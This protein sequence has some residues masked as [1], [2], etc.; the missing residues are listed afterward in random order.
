M[1]CV[2]SIK[3]EY[4]G[5]T[6]SGESVETHDMAQLDHGAAVDTDARHHYGLALPG[7]SDSGPTPQS[8]RVGEFKLHGV[9]S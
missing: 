5:L 6:Y 8:E 4:T 7:R 1:M 3:D 9:T 2:Y